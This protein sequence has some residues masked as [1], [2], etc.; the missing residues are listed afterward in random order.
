MENI[1]KVFEEINS[2][3][4]AT[5]VY[6]LDESQL[7]EFVDFLNKIGCKTTNTKDKK[8]IDNIR[9]NTINSINNLFLNESMID[10]ISYI[11]RS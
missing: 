7:C 8:Y 5:D 4:K 9:L 10:I 1:K 6:S 3:L 11:V 2:Y